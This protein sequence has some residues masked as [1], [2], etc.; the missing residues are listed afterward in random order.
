MRDFRIL[1]EGVEF[2][3]LGVTQRPSRG[4]V[5]GIANDSVI[6]TLLRLGRIEEVF[7]N[8]AETPP[9]PARAEA[10]PA[11]RGAQP[12]VTSPVEGDATWA[13]VPGIS[14]PSLKLLTSNAKDANP[15][16]ATEDEILG[17]LGGSTRRAR[18]VVAALGKYK[19]SLSAGEGG[20]V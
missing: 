15:L 7:A 10:A 14:K 9:E 16:E 6:N 13:T 3:D 5:V 12:P 2:L 19:D 11:G 4:D 17:W 18:L 1:E 8:R 20:D